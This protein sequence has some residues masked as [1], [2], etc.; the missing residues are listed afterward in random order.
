MHRKRRVYLH[1]WIAPYAKS[2]VIDHADGDGLNCRR[3]NFR[4]TS[5]RN[6]AINHPTQSNN[7]SGFKGVDFVPRYQKYRARITTTDGRRHLGLFA[8]ADQA[9]R[10]YDR[11]ARKHHGRYARLN[12]PR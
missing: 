4:Y 3:G 6:N 10:A 12:F 7:T 9:A 8:L 2:Q 5:H 1:R 11:A